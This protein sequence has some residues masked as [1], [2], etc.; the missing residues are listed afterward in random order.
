M[1][2]SAIRYG[3]VWLG[4]AA[5]VAYYFSLDPEAKTSLAQLV[6]RDAAAVAAAVPPPVAAPAPPAAAPRSASVV[7][8]PR[9]NGQFY[10]QGHVG[11][12]SVAFLVDT[13]ASTVALTLQDARRAGVDVRALRYDVPVSTANGRAMAARARLDEVRIGGIRVRDVDA[14]VMRDGL[15]ISLLG[16]TFLGQLQKV[17]ATPQQLILRY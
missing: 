14:L 10:T 1:S 6:G 7:S 15:H 17:E 11:R 8:I 5:A 9:R 16:M 2:G 4:A 13:G 3:L 12:G